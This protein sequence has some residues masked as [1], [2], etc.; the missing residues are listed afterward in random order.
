MGSPIKVCLHEVQLFE[1][2]KV[3]QSV[4]AIQY[5]SSNVGMHVK[6]KPSLFECDDKFSAQISIYRCEC[7]IVIS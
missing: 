7:L 2:C 1:Q 3:D 5:R 4:D 6:T